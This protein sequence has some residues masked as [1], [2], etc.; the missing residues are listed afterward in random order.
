VMGV[1]AVGRWSAGTTSSMGL[2]MGQ[3]KAV[4]EATAARYRSASK[5]ARS[6]ILDEL[7][8]TT[9]WHRDHARKA[10]RGALGPTRTPVPRRPRAPVYGEEVLA[11]L[12][13]VWAVMDAPAGRRMAPFLG[14]IVARPRACGELDT[15]DETAARLCAMSAATIDR[16]LA[17]ERRR[18]Q[19][20][21][22]SGTKPGSLLKSQIPIRTWA[23]W[24]EEKVGFVEVDCVGHEGGN[25]RGHFCQTLTVT[26]VR[27]AWTETAAVKDK[28]HRRVFAA[29][30]DITAAFP[31]P[32]LGIDSDNGSEFINEQ[33]LRYCTE[34]NITFTRARAGHKND[35]AH[36]EQKNWSVV[37]RTVGYHRYDT[38]PEL[39]LLNEIYPLLGLMTNFFTPSQKLVHKHRVGAKVTR[40]YDEA[41]TPYQPVMADPGVAKETK[42]ALTGR[43]LGL[44]PAQIRRDLL[45]LQDE[46]LD[47]VRDKQPRTRLRASRPI[48]SR[49][50]SD[51]A[52]KT[53]SRAS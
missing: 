40:R 27:S 12:R 44:N 33:L 21:G 8:A 46:P 2:T 25:P 15:S 20:K 51:E 18:L 30:M 1:P 53:R 11:P 29:L 23:Q 38:A 34:Q 19:L 37:R 35:G 42:T 3:R 22:R 50:K 32:I 26:D 17:G 7:C 14:E 5:A 45:D 9:G 4:T 39:A 47:L 41:A 31:F 49:A 13:K 16:R 43:Y 48:T 28:A 52:T 10:L 24:D 6:V 36:V